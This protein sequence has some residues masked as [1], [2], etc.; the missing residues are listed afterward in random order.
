MPSSLYTGV[1]RGSETLGTL[2]VNAQPHSLSVPF[3]LRCFSSGEHFPFRGM[4]C[5]GV[6]GSL[7]QGLRQPSNISRAF[8][9]PPD[10][11]EALL[12][13]QGPWRGDQLPRAPTWRW[14]DWH[15]AWDRRKQTRSGMRHLGPLS[16]GLSG[17][18]GRQKWFH[19]PSCHCPFKFSIRRGYARA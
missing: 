8:R 6:V 9:G 5:S 10:L 16:I 12:E 19:W 13:E 14:A 1:K 2:Q 17:S 15:P 4:G 7:G 11:P 18:A 3:C